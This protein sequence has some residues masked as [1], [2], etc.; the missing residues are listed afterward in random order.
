MLCLSIR[1]ASALARFYGSETVTLPFPGSLLTPIYPALYSAALEGFFSVKLWE[2]KNII[3]SL[4]SIFT[5]SVTIVQYFS[6]QF[7]RR[8]F[9]EPSSSCFAGPV[10]PTG[11]CAFGW[12][13]SAG[14]GLLLVFCILP[15]QPY[16]NY[17]VELQ[18]GEA[19]VQVIRA[20]KLLAHMIQ[21]S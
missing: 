14:W 11:A 7:L 2:E 4:T 5:N 3:H 17:Q 13:S 20:K 12:A 10:I 21:A 8:G 16:R 6:R 19:S 15:T 9:S 1:C 18:G